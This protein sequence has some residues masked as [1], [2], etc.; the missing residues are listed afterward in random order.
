MLV[1]SKVGMSFALILLFVVA[2]LTITAQSQER[3]RTLEKITGKNEPVEIEAK[4]GTKSV[5]LGQGFMADND[6]LSGLSFK[7]KNH[8]VKVHSEGTNNEGMKKSSCSDWRELEWPR[9]QTGDY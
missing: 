8:S 3:I 2:C 7:V 4:V 6:W 1:K 5:R 9:W